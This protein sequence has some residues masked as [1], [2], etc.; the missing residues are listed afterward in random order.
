MQ[1]SRTVESSKTYRSGLGA[2]IEDCDLLFVLPLNTT[3]QK[4]DAPKQTL[5]KHV[6]RVAEVR[7]G[8]LETHALKTADT[9]NRF[10]Q[11]MER[12]DFGVTHDG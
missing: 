2:P 6:Q 9:I 5:I 4:H 3:F 8:V 10:A 1:F 12:L 11:R 7:R